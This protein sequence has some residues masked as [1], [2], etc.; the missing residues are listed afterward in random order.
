MLYIFLGS[1]DNSPIF[2]QLLLVLSVAIGY[3]CL[4]YFLGLH[5]FFSLLIDQ[6]KVKL[7]YTF[8]V[9]TYIFFSEDM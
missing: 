9:Y 7:Q 1:I 3:L 6:V 4:R 8:I 2:S 5:H